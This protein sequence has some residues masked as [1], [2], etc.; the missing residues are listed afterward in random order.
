[1]LIINNNTT[2]TYCYASDKM[3][4]SVRE[5]SV[6][7]AKLISQEPQE[8]HRYISEEL[9]PTVVHFVRE[10]FK[11]FKDK[12]FDPDDMA[13]HAFVQVLQRVQNRPDYFITDSRGKSISISETAK[14]IYAAFMN[15]VRQGRTG[16]LGLAKTKGHGWGGQNRHNIEYNVTDA[17]PNRQTSP[18]LVPNEFPGSGVGSHNILEQWYEQ[19]HHG[20]EPDYLE[21]RIRTEE[22]QSL[23]RLISRVAN[24]NEH[25]GY[26]LSRLAVLYG[27]PLTSISRQ[28]INI[29]GMVSKNDIR[30]IQS[31][32]KGIAQSHDEALIVNK[33]IPLLSTLSNALPPAY[34][35][36]V[37]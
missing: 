32:L 13:Q 21:S 30:Q 5:F 23:M 12:A 33:L 17:L 22:Y 26:I 6:K 1:M 34:T 18:S 10:K 8:I 2:W 27:Q 3:V 29:V 11:S 16:G 19:E 35:R 4:S 31:K 7:L 20:E 36:S 28:I 24:E 25:Y 37:I 15:E 9:F 14:K